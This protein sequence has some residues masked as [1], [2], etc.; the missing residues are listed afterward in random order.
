MSYGRYAAKKRQE[1]GG[2]VE[3]FQMPSGGSLDTAGRRAARRS[4]GSVETKT[5]KTNPVNKGLDEFLTHPDIDQTPASTP[6]QRETRAKTYSAL[7]RDIPA[8]KDPNNT[9]ATGSIG[10]LSGGSLSGP[11]NTGRVLDQLRNDFGIE[12]TNPY[13]TAPVAGSRASIAQ[14]AMKPGAISFSDVDM[15]GGIP[16]ISDKQRES[17]VDFGQKPGA[18]QFTAPVDMESFAT[19]KIVSGMEKNQAPIGSGDDDL[20][21]DAKY[22]TS[23]RSA[24]SRAFLD[25]DG[26]GGILGAMRAAE[27]TDG[28][29]YYGGR[30][31]LMDKEGDLQYIS[32]DDARGLQYGKTTPQDILSKHIEGVPEK[33]MEKVF[34]TGDPES[35]DPTKEGM[36]PLQP[37]EQLSEPPASGGEL[38]PQKLYNTTAPEGGGPTGFT[39]PEEE[40]KFPSF[41]KRR[42]F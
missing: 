18:G 13:D 36:T 33:A 26:P 20:G 4:T 34:A 24:R 27:A 8:P 32:K 25:Y 21:E 1:E 9:G 39:M 16:R 22:A 6:E 40:D 15:T 11:P 38:N 19:Q 5:T 14:M 37:F 17:G 3:R 35:I 23:Q 7:G 31:M 41:S 12:L 28:V 2:R 10:G 30:H 42:R 29:A